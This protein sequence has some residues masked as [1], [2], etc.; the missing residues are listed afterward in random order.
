M[1]VVESRFIMTPTIDPTISGPVL[2]PAQVGGQR[3]HLDRLIGLLIGLLD[4]AGPECYL[5]GTTEHVA[6]TRR[7]F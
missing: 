1:Q 3:G 5:E 6:W 7:V 2:L 4:L